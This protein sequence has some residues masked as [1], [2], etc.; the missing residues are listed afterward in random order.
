MPINATNFALELI[1]KKSISGEEDFGAID[2]LVDTLSG[3]GFQNEVVRFSE[4]GTYDVDNLYS[5][6]IG[7]SEVNLCFAGHTDVVPVGEESSWTVSPFEPKIVDGQL[8]GRGAVDMKG[9]IA[10]WVSAVSR[11]LEEVS[12]KPK[13]TL[14]FLITGDE[15]A[16]AINGTV[17]L[18][19]HISDKGKKIDSCIVGEP[20]NPEKLGEMMK[21]GR[22]GSVSFDLTITGI[23]G[24][25]AYPDVADNPNHIIAK[26]LNDLVRVELDKGNDYFQ[27]SSLQVTTIDVGNA[28]S[29]VIPEKANAKLNIRFNTEH[30]RDSLI[31][32]VDS[33]CAEHSDNYSLEVNQGS[34]P[35]LS[36]PGKLAGVV[37]DA[38]K[39]VTS[40]ELVKSTTGGTSDARFIKDY[41]EVVE[42]GLI[43]KTAH[44]VD[45]QV[46][47]QD[48]ES[49]SDI[50]LSIIKKY[51]Q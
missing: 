44:K 51:F 28:A 35:F 30:D 2:L 5:E 14:S 38:V 41:S 12:G 13:G 8:V 3:L 33:I 18:L 17:K 36:E 29:N 4:E 25:I 46:A 11:Y 32:L 26:I 31:K 42:F 37:F 40:M 27:P 22:R 48:I 21:V 24:H 39:E 16:D 20:T 1:S 15:E 34:S 45:E 43:N 10:A 49:L 6:I 23:Q 19:K 47:A 50:Y 7:E 9:A